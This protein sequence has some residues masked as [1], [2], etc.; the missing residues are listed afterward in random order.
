MLSR[1]KSWE[2]DHQLSYDPVLVCFIHDRGE[3]PDPQ[4]F[5]KK[6]ITYC[7]PRYIISDHHFGH[8]NIIKYC[9]RPFTSVGEMNNILID[10]YY[11]TIGDDATLIHLGDVAMDMQNGE[12]TI[13][14]FQQLGGDVLIQGNHDVGLKP[15]EAPF[16]IFNSCVI[17][18]NEYTFYCTHRPEDIPDEWNTWAI[19]GHIHNN[20][21][22]EYP[23][24]AYDKQRVNVSSELLDYRPIALETLTKLLDICPPNMRLRDRDEARE[25]ASSSI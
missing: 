10:R 14:Y 25:F 12:K 5:I 23:F 18:H 11:E 8:A 1:L 21:T 24:V 4:Y 6:T 3:Y 17:E 19:H 20:N 7:M 16:P 9:D 15:E 13:K 2:G 22:D